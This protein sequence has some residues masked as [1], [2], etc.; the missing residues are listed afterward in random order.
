MLQPAQLSMNKSLQVTSDPINGSANPKAI[1][2]ALIEY[3]LTVTNGGEGTADTD[4]VTI[5]DS[6]PADTAFFVG[7]DPSVSPVTLTEGATA[8]TLTLNFENL[9]STTDDVEFSDNNGTTF[10]YQPTP[11]AEGFDPL[12]T[13]VRIRLG[14]T[15]PGTD[16]DGSPEFSIFY[17]VKVN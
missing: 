8:S 2:G 5:T 1:P 11:D 7:T 14:G 13:D 4:T 12:I 10:D 17:Q 3:Q 9:T 16:E 6:L 15:M